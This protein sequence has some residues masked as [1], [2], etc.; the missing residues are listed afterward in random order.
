MTQTLNARVT[1]KVSIL[2]EVQLNRA[3]QGRIKA[4]SDWRPA[5]RRIAENYQAV[6]QQQFAAEGAAGGNPKWSPLSA[7]YAAWK[8]K[9]YPG[10][11]LLTRTGKLARL[12][13]HPNVELQPLALTLG[14]AGYRVG[15]WDLPALHQTG[16]RKMPARKPI[17]LTR[18]QKTAWMRILRDL[19]SGEKTN[20]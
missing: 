10:A 5:W 20:G 11:K 8:S 3:L 16:T 9:H 18:R 14:F 15:R 7:K 12:M 2:G 4:V 17:N 13:T 6:E 19:I 1:L